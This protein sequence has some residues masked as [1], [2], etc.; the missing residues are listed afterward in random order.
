MRVSD[1]M[2]GIGVFGRIMLRWIFRKRDVGH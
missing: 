2:E 1:D